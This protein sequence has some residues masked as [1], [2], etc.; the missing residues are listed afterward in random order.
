ME[1]TELKILEINEIHSYEKQK[2][3]HIKSQLDPIHIVII[4]LRLSSD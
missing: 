3:K 4:A 1:K 2:F